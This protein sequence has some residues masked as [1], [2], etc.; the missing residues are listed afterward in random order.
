MGG[1]SNGES[2]AGSGAVANAGETSSN[3]GGAAGASAG[4]PALGND[5]TSPG[6]LACAG[7]HQKLTLVCGAD[8]TWV[9]NE[10]CPSGQFCSSTPGPDLGVCLA[11]PA[12]CVEQVPGYRS[13]A[14]DSV[15]EC[16]PDTVT[17]EVVEE[18]SNGCTEGVC[19]QVECPDNLL[20][21]CG[22]PCAGT[23]GECYDLCGALA[24]SDQP[25]LLDPLNLIAGQEY[26]IELPAVEGSLACTCDFITSPR[27]ASF[28]Y[29][30]P[31]LADAFWRIRV[32]GPWIVS[33]SQYAPA[34]QSRGNGCVGHRYG[35]RECDRW[36][37]GLGDAIVWLETDQTPAAPSMVS[38]TWGS[39]VQTACD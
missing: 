23:L 1:A 3:L 2:G 13:C 16:G 21:S 12:E 5:C 6:A 32:E 38:V 37:V 8:N 14:G 15:I 9:T 29:R 25:P 28:A 4:A 20:F 27:L 31:E 10:T 24:D 34:M 39:E 30:L 26:F 35:G 11:P 33:V 36:F 19:T 18:C 17:T 22:G 7:T